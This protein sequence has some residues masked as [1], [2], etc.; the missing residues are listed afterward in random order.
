ML[1][2]TIPG[3]GQ[4][5]DPLVDPKL[6]TGEGVIEDPTLWGIVSAALPYVFWIAG[7]ILFFVLTFGGFNLLTSFGNP[8]KVKKG[9]QMIVS[10]L[11]GFAVIFISYWLIQ[12]LEIALGINLF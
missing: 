4:V 10:G 11:I 9:Q 7:I 1:Q 6:K 5:P 3:F 2:L 12:V 8:D